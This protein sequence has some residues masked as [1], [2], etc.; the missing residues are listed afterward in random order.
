MLE[1][2]QRFH[3]I[4]FK[5]KPV[6]SERRKEE[7]SAGT[8]VECR[9]VYTCATIHGRSDSCEPPQ[10][11]VSCEPPTGAAVLA[12]IRRV[13]TPPLLSAASTAGDMIAPRA[14]ELE[15]KEDSSA[16]WAWWSDLHCWFGHRASR[17]QK[18]P[19]V[20]WPRCGLISRRVLSPTSTA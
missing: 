19:R 20:P 2:A 10:H 7:N 9:I 15:H 18:M 5:I 17:P 6:R 12:R 11:C 13:L 3:S 8:V 16:R 1:L 4:T 14:L